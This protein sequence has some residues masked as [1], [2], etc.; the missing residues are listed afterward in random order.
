MKLPQESIISMLALYN[1]NVLCTCFCIQVLQQQYNT[2]NTPESYVSKYV[3]M[4][5]CR[6]L[7]EYVDHKMK[8]LRQNQKAGA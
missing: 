1:M 3:Q 5:Y 7:A 2:V 4:H 6:V 8:E